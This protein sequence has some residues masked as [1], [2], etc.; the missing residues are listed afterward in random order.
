[1]RL[2][3][4]PSGFTLIELLITISIL[5]IL[6]AVATPSFKTFT[7]NAELREVSK[8]LLQDLRFA[9]DKARA[10]GE[11]VR[12]TPNSGDLLAGWTIT[13]VPATGS[14]L[15]L[16]THGPAAS[17]IEV[18]TTGLDAGYAEFDRFGQASEAGSATFKIADCASPD[19]VTLELLPSGQILERETPCT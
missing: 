18:A 14:P 8:T 19:V 13:A 11:T 16:R 17:M 6:L 2:L 12:L 5:G 10:R 4:R 1:M 15:T 3:T 9:R 7:D